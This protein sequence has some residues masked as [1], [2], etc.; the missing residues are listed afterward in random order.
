MDKVIGAIVVVLLIAGA[1]TLM[2]RS[3]R[4]RRLRDGDLGGYPEPDGSEPL[5]LAVEVL[6]VATTPADRPVERLAIPGLAFRAEA[7]LELSRAGMLVAA[8]GEPPVFVP[9]EQITGVATASWVIDRGVEA[10]G[11]VV[12]GWIARYQSTDEAATGVPVESYFRARSA[13]DAGRIIG[14]ITDLRGAVPGRR[15]DTEG[16]A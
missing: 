5:L 9:A 12:I 3:W 10:E 14:I 6:Y 8:T 15:T 16:G 2:L 11:L 7:R 13:G 1:I 4:R